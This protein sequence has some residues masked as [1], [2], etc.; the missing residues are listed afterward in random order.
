MEVVETNNIKYFLQVLLNDGNGYNIHSGVFT[1]SESGVYLFSYFIGERDVNEVY[2]RLVK[3]SALETSAVVQTEHA[4]QDLQGGNIVIVHANSG[5]V[6]WVEIYAN[7]HIQGSSF[8]R[9]TTFS[10]VF[11]YALNQ[12]ILK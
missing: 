1:C 6:V 3:N 5:D 2:T 7:Q 4:T 9:L 12:S 10:G 11:L 8:V